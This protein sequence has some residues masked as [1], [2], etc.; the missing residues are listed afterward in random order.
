MQR[1]LLAVDI[2][3]TLVND[4]KEILPETKRD[5]WEYIRQGGIFV[6]A[7]G[8]ATPGV[9]RYIRELELESRGGYVVA[10]NGART[11]CPKEGRVI[12]ET[13][14]P[15]EAYDSILEAADALDLPLIAYRN[16][17]AVT[18]KANDRYF[19]LETSING[20][21]IDRV[22][23][24]RAALDFDTPKFMITGE[25][26]F[27]AGA[28]PKLRAALL[29]APVDVYRSEPCFLEIT[30]HGSDKGAAILSLAASLGLSRA[31]TMACGDGFN[32]V[33]MLRRVG[34]GVAMANAQAPAK[35]AADAGTLSNAEN[36]VGE[37]IRRYAL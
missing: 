32:D 37:A 31:D 35:A 24:L 11:F 28:E 21:E 13:R 19:H 25:P 33:S 9:G 14:V 12:A 18:E 7:T 5:I 10:Y 1:R 2:D 34:F 26:E 4:Q 36:G 27:L 29:G 3:G 17:V 23:S 8:R 20:L 6:L 30:A 16:D 15:R 22:A